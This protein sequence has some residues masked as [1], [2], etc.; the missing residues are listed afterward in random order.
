MFQLLSEIHIPERLDQDVSA[1]VCCILVSFQLE[2]REHQRTLSQLLKIHT[3]NLVKNERGIN[4]QLEND[5][6]LTQTPPF[7]SY[8]LN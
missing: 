8:V 1:K 6:D 3:K 7:T 5:E 4:G 2:N